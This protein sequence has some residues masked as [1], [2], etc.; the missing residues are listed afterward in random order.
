MSEVNYLKRILNI[1]KKHK[2]II[3][4][5]SLSTLLLIFA[6]MFNPII[7][8]K[9]A[10]E[11]IVKKDLSVVFELL[12]FFLIITIFRAI[13]AFIRDYLLDYL[14]SETAKKL[15]YELYTHIQTLSFSYFDNMNTG[16]LMSRISE[17]I[18]LIWETIA[19]GLRI[20]IESIIY[21]ITASIILF[22]I[23]W[24]LT[25]MCLSIMPFLGFIVYKLQKSIIK[26]YEKLSDQAT[27]L[28][29]AAQEN[30]A[31]V[32]LVKAF[33]REKYEILKFLKLNKERYELSLNQGKINSKYLP[34]LE[35][36]SNLSLIVMI[37]GGGY[38]VIEDKMTLGTLVTYSG[39]IGMIIWP[40]RNSGWLSNMISQC[41]ASIKKINEI[42]IVKPEIKDK[43]DPISLTDYRGNIEFKNVFYNNNDM[44]ILKDI[45]INL[46]QG[47]T[48]AIMGATGSGKTSLINLISRF[49]DV[50]YGEILLDGIEIKN[51]KINDFRKDIAYVPQ[52]TFLFSDTISEN[53]RYGKES[54]SIDEIREA[55]SLSCAMEFIDELEEGFDT[56]I[57]ERGLGLSGGQ[58]QRLAI[59]RALISDSKILIL[60][61][62]TSALDMETEYELL[63]NLHKSKKRTTIIIAH[64]ISAVK[65]ADEII[66]I[67]DG[68][69]V[70]RGNHTEL[71]NK[72][73]LYYSIFKEQFKDF[74]DY[75]EVV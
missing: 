53:I 15:K 43:E 30:L 55:C 13:F 21:L 1:F 34:L 23:N 35:V 19:Y 45:N 65:N 48:L 7:S 41:M 8:G 28:N 62:A 29:T 38:F 17:D 36:L 75:K 31:G 49:Y 40:I 11:V 57:G 24:K 58:K 44:K 12:L 25:L 27:V 9:F 56:V 16:E 47:K 42:F 52:E 2:V 32:R 66:Y 68:F 14:G 64:R 72:K 74:E 51:I 20:A 61:D 50:S 73:G 10:D 4:I 70:E 39:Y 69:I 59:A 60:D 26:N 67:D 37:V 6:D 46:K 22:S 54:A 63:T 5:S 3:F 18:S 71:L 33:A